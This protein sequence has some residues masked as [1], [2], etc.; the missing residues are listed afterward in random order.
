M[1]PKLKKL[2]KDFSWYRTDEVAAEQ[3]ALLS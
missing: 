2:L 1:A 3:A